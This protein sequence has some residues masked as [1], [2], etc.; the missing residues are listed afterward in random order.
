MSKG[1]SEFLLQQAGSAPEALSIAFDLLNRGDLQA[2]AGMFQRLLMQA[3]RNAEAAFGLGQVA[4]RS[5]DIKGAAKLFAQAAQHNPQFVEAYLMLGNAYQQ[6]GRIPQAQQAYRSGLAAAPDNPN[7]HYNLGVAQR[8]AGDFDSAIASYQTAIRLKPDYAR[9]YFSLGNA[10][11]DQGRMEEAES[12]YLSAVRLQPDFAD[13]QTN[14]GGLYAAREEHARALPCYEAALRSQPNHLI[15]QK[16]RS[17]TLYKLGRFREGAEATRLALLLAPNE[18]M[19]HYQMGEM[20]YGLVRE[21]DR[22]TA[23]RYAEGWQQA[24]PDN[25][26][27]KHMSAAALGEKPP[28]RADD[29]YVKE[30]FD[31]F[32]VDFEK[33]LGGLNYRAPQLLDQALQPFL[34]E[35]RDLTILDAGCGTGLCA[36]LLKPR[37]R[38]LVGVDLSPGMLAKAYD[39]KLYDQLAE[40]ELGAF[41]A[42]TTD[43]YDVTVAA[44]VFCYFGELETI[45]KATAGKMTPDGLL[46]F[47]VERIAG[48]AP[49]EGFRLDPTGRYAHS[50]SYLRQALEKAGLTAKLFEESAARVEMEKPVPCFLVVAAKA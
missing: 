38:K 45:F 43:R 28:E 5:G 37:A 27:A 9:A 35:R 15:A 39:R 32:A 50:E 48:D 46:A 14:L 22:E 1:I 40:V 23:K 26:V 6:L 34:G 17:L 10:H 7:L 4:A 12:A 20:L 25:P 16:N 44:D 21:G 47:T 41:L 24:Y 36:P 3:P 42:K 13:A 18:M 19:I 31:R 8:L 2:A 11:R 29:A 49:A 33:V 30:T